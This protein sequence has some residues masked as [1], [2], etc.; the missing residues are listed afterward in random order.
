MHFLEKGSIRFKSPKLILMILRQN[1]FLNFLIPFCFSNY[2][3]S[4]SYQLAVIYTERKHRSSGNL[5]IKLYVI[6]MSRT[7]FRVNPHSIVCL[8]VKERFSRNRHHIWSFLSDSNN[9]P[10][11]NHL[12]R[13]RT[14]NHL[15]K[16]V[17][18]VSLVKW[19]SVRL[20]DKWWWVRISLNIKP[21]KFEY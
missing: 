6:I 17:F 8:N 19:L 1:A 20:R 18:K 11:H 14:L 7:S 13:K 4:W 15:A 5:K 16:L 3:A 9:I 21:C 2:G 10:N 12:V